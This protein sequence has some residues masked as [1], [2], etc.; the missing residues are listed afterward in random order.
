MDNNRIIEEIINNIESS[1]LINDPFDHKFVSNVLPQ[2][3][4]KE[5]LLNLPT[6]TEYPNL[7]ESGRVGKDYSKERYL[8]NLSDQSIIQNFSDE[9][10]LFIKKLINIFTSSKIF[11]SVS[12]Q[13]FRTLKKRFQNFSE[14]EKNLYGENNFK[15]K[16]GLSLVKDFTKYSMGVHTDARHKF[17]TFLFYLPKDKNLSNIGTTLYKAKI[18]QIDQKIIH[19]SPKESQEYFKPIKRCPF[20]PNSLLVF[21]RTNYSYHGVE[22]VNIHQQERDLLL[23]NYH[24]KK[25]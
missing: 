7:F 8:L 13:F 23:L 3:F 21:P 20:V 6:K 10:Q 15:F 9:K 4:Y 18:D 12:K 1:E 16:I 2:D 5:I 25:I 17:L 19:F 22:E 14:K 11:Q 24:L